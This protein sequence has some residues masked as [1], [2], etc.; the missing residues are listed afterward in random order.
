MTQEE[1]DP[2]ALAPGTKIGPYTVVSRLGVGGMG[3]VYKVERDGHVRA[4]KLS[5]QKHS[6]LTEQKRAEADG[7]ARRE[8]ATLAAINHPNV[9]HVWGFDRW[10]DAETGYLYV[11]MDYIQGDRLYLWRQKHKPP[12]R[13]IAGVFLHLADAL[14]ELHRHEVFHR[15]IKSENLIIREDGEPILIDFGISRQSSAYTL[16]S[17]GSLLGTS[18]HLSPEYCQYVVGNKG[19]KGARYTFRA[20]DDLHAVGVML[21]E[22]LTGRPPF[23]MEGQNEWALLQDIAHTAP[24]RPRALNPSIPESLELLIMRLLAKDGAERIR[25]SEDLTRALEAVLETA[26]AAWDVPFTVPGPEDASKKQTFDARGARKSKDAAPK[27]AVADLLLDNVPV[28]AE[29]GPGAGAAAPVPEVAP[30]KAARFSSPA[31]PNPGFVPPEEEVPAGSGT[32]PAAPGVLTTSLRVATEQLARNAP[33]RRQRRL[34]ALA[35]L[36]VVLLLLVLVSRRP[37]E[38]KPES[39]LQ[40]VERGQQTISITSSSGGGPVPTAPATSLPPSEPPSPAAPSTSPVQQLSTSPARASAPAASPSP[41]HR[42]T[43]PAPVVFIGATPAQ[44]PPKPTRD[45][46][47]WI[48]TAEVIDSSPATQEPKGPRKLGVPLGTHLKVKLKSN[49]DSRTVDAGLVEAVLIQ[50]YVAREE[51]VLPSRT[52]LY[53]KAQARGERFFIRF[54]KLRLPDDTELTFQGSALDGN[55]KT[56]GLASTRWIRNV[57]QPTNDLPGTVAKTAANVLLGKVGGDT[58]SDVAGAAGR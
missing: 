1:I 33:D 18:S 19:A 10:P 2:T 47:S 34:L 11:V 22:L 25:T 4:L 21:F 28:K 17:A 12:L 43:A 3:A 6:E 29:P 32:Q 26:D 24:P 13:H 44:S 37:A 49:L 14:H 35:G 54:T 39:L 53:G 7:R 55:D 9:V 20:T 51:L 56:P 30:A 15:D 42:K 58:A 50:P 45:L 52:L 36:A 41:K 23:V 16:T 40:Q 38:S 48:K 46:P 8:V 57:A 5:S 31:R 27:N